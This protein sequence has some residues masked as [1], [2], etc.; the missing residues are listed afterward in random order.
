[1]PD[2]EC[3]DTSS[4]PCY[5][6]M[7]NAAQGTTTMQTLTRV[8]AKHIEATS[9]NMVAQELKPGEWEVI[10]ITKCMTREQA[11][12]I[13]ATY[14]EM[15]AQELTPGEWEVVDITECMTMKE[16]EAWLSKQDCG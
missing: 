14:A 6:S 5:N 4:Q 8:Q 7:R 13:E 16:Y 10:N 11:K 15:I 9:P 2:T 3:F 1:M 12:R